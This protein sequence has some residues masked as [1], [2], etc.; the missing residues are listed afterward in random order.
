VSRRL[1]WLSIPLREPFVT[2]SGSTRARDLVVLR[3]EERDGV[4]A[5]GEAAPFEP[6]DG[7]SV[8]AV[9]YAMQERATPSLPHVHTA[10]E[11]AFLDLEGRRM[12]EP[13]LDLR[14]PSVP[15]NCTLAGA[16]PEDVAASAGAAA[17]E[18]FDCFKLKVGLPDDEARVAAVRDAIGPD[19]LLRLDANAAW[20]PDQARRHIQRLAGYRI[21]FVEQPCRT[22]EELAEVRRTTDVRIAADEAVQSEDDVIAAAEA[23]ACDLVSVK[24][25]PMGG[26]NAARSAIRA[27]RSRGLE[28]YVSS[29]LD[30][31]WGIAAALQLA[32]AEGIGLHCGLA[33]LGL[34][35]AAIADALPR[36]RGGR[37]DVPAGPGLGV[38]VEWDA[39]AEVL[40]QEL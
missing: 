23:G 3:L 17:A 36:P 14:E 34:F 9:A 22:L 21:E 18:G 27:A 8:A 29:S 13:I 28:A 32:S 1:L 4:I 37:M 26:L 33:T 6:Y 5:H 12:G 40:V 25:A 39:I 35:D 11:M 19:A 31:P 24:L 7:V 30:G 15:V 38:D 20:T 16:T 2:S 10:D